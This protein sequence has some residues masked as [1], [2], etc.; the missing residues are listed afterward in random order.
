MSVFIIRLFNTYG[1]DKDNFSFIE[2][3]IRAKKNKTQIKLINEGISFRDFIHV[4][5]VSKIYNFFV[6]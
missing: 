5:D 4:D 3:I 1:N 6:I 2:K